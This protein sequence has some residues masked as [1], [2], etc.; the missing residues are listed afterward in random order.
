[1]RRIGTLEDPSQAKNFCD[2]LLTRQIDAS[3]D[4]DP[5]QHDI[6]IREESDVEPARK[7]LA[8]FRENPSDS[9]Y[10]VGDE[11]QRIR[12]ARVAE[13]SRRLKNL[14][15]FQGSKLPRGM[16]GGMGGGRSR[17]TGTPLTIAIIVISVIA[18]FGTDFGRV[19]LPKETVPNFEELLDGE[20]QA[21]LTMSFVDRYQYRATDG[22]SFASIKQGQLWRFVTPMFLHGSEL[23][24]LFNM[25]WIYTLGSALERLHGSAF[26]LGL[27][28]V[29]QVSGMLVQV[30]LPDWLPEGLRGYPFAIGASGAVY[31]LFG[32]IWIRPRFE[33]MYPIAIPPQNVMLML[34]WLVLCMTPIIGQVANGA[35]LGGLGAGVAAAA[36]WRKNTS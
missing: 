22:D 3:W 7:E 19:K 13:N 33:P 6:W 5:G 32:F 21:Y 27:V 18:S 8:I 16:G 15:K 28:M 2:Y 23:H 30:L 34:G 9:R 31:G 10:S 24:L 1:M 14:K 26:F 35:H 4:E 11:V 36:L 17:Q 20:A 12:E 29:T 25:L